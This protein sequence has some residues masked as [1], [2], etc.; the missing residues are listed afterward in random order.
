MPFC[1][2]M[3][4]RK[5]VDDIRRKTAIY[6]RF[7]VR[8]FCGVTPLIFVSKFLSG[9]RS[10]N[11]YIWLYT[12]CRCLFRIKIDFYKVFQSIYH[13]FPVSDI[14]L[15]HRNRW[16]FIWKIVK[17]LWNNNI[18]VC[19]CVCVCV[20]A[21]ACACVC[22]CYCV[23]ACYAKNETLSLNVIPAFFIIKYVLVIYIH[24]SFGSPRT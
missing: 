11:M 9:V 24:N 3:Y 14:L 22:V 6:V 8:T 12:A 13:M 21:C 23:S 4:V 15:Y 17:Y 2:K 5:N 18:Y 10:E 20:C 16:L 1:R 7:A 19:V